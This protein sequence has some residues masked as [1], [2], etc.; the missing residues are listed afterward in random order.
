M[1]RY[2]SHNTYDYI[3][4]KSEQEKNKS[5]RIF[6]VSL[7]LGSVIGAICWATIVKKWM[8]KVKWIYKN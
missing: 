6:V 8:I 4:E 7:I 3:Y 5:K 1:S 2:V